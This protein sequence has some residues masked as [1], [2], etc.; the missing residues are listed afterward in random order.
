MGKPRTSAFVLRL[1]LLAAALLPLIFFY[2]VWHVP[3]KVFL[4]GTGSWGFGVIFKMLFHQLLLR[5]KERRGGPLLRHSLVNGFLSGFFELL[6][7]LAV[8]LLTREKVVYDHHGM[9]AFGTAIGSLE[10]LLVVF[11]RGD[12]LLRGTVLEGPAA[13]MR[14]LTERATG[15]ER[16]LLQLLYPFLERVMAMLIHVATRGLL[17]ITLVTGHILPLL[18]ALLIFVLADGILGTWFYLT[19]RLEKREGIDRF[20]G[21]LFLLALTGMALFLYLDEV[22]QMQEKIF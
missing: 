2:E 11:S 22:F 5:P 18:A 3:V 12:E 14:A 21:W 19:G 20:M 9:I 13:R 6:A 16:L 4:L 10:M 1:L 7:A 8:I 15:I 17:F